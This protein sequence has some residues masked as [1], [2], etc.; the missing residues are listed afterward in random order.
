MKSNIT[1]KCMYNKSNYKYIIT[2]FKKL[3]NIFDI[4]E[5]ST[6]LSERANSYLYFYFVNLKTEKSLLLIQELNVNRS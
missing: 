6:Y 1:K 5:F 2:L 4:F 3:F